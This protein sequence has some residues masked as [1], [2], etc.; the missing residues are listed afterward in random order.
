MR[1]VSLP[2]WYTLFSL[3]PQGVPV[4]D[5]LTL[6]RALEYA[7]RARGQVVS[8]RGAVDRARAEARRFSAIPNP[9]LQYGSSDL[10]PTQ[11]VQLLQPLSWLAGF[12]QARAAGSAAVRRASADSMRS[13][14]EVARSVRVAFYT[15]VAA[16][17]T[18]RL[19]RD[20][21][22]AADTLLQ[23]AE[24]RS[25]L[26]DISE[27]ERDQV[28]QETATI[29]I[30]EQR[31]IADA[32][33]ARL[34]L[35][36][37]LGAVVTP[38]VVVAARLDDRLPFGSGQTSWTPTTPASVGD[39]PLV[40]MAIHDSAAAANRL[41]V[42]R[43]RQLPLPS[44]LGKWEW[45]GGPAAARNTI[46]GFSVPLPLWQYGQHDVALARAEAAERSG[47]AIE[48]RLEGVRQLEEGRVRV[49]ES[50]TRAQDARTQLFPT[51]VRLRAGAVRLFEAGRTGILP[52][53]DAFRREREAAML[54]VQEMLAYQVARAELAALLGREP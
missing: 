37:A 51:A 5:T 47:G 30:M 18:L 2:M 44:F 17:E 52:V 11:S 45:G 22:R 54:M 27:L 32:R 29:R 25:S 35:G 13:T 48:A 33:V 50:S 39:V 49:E 36:R 8:A 43:W 9:V 16:D 14:A 19:V 21:A 31:A 20:H 24:R 1:V 26:G 53:F 15:T 34:E 12:G 7:A 38:A 40:A 28:V 42:A 23:L 6:D 10:T 41:A 4:A 46:L 3:L